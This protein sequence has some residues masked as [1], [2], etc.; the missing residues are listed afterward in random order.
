MVKQA[1]KIVLRGMLF[2]EAAL[3]AVYGEEGGDVRK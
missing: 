2:A 1:I 3:R